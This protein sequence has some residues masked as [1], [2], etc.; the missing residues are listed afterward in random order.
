MNKIKVAAFNELKTFGSTKKYLKYNQMNAS[1]NEVHVMFNNAFTHPNALIRYA[2]LDCV[3]YAYLIEGN[4]FGATTVSKSISNMPL[5]SIAD[6]GLGIGDFINNEI[7][8]IKFN[9]ES[10]IN[11]VRTNPSVFDIPK[12]SKKR[13]KSS[14]VKYFYNHT[15]KSYTIH[16]SAQISIGNHPHFMIID[17]NLYCAVKFNRIPDDDKS[18]ELQYVP[19]NSLEEFEVTSG[20]D[21]SI[22]SSNNKFPTLR[23]YLW[24][25]RRNNYINSMSLA[26]VS[27]NIRAAFAKQHMGMNNIK[28]K[29]I[30][31]ATQ[32]RINLK[33]YPVNGLIN[34]DIENNTIYHYNDT[35]SSGNI[36]KKRFY[37]GITGQKAINL[38]A[39]NQTMKK[40]YPS[41]DV[42]KF[43][44][45]IQVE[46]DD[47]IKVIEDSSILEQEDGQYRF[48]AIP[49]DTPLGNA[50][51]EE[52]MYI[53]SD[54][55]HDNISAR[56]II[57]KLDTIGIDKYNINQLESNS[58]L[59]INIIFDYVREEGD[60]LEN[61]IN[62]FPCDDGVTR[63][64]DDDEV[65]KDIFNN[66][67]L[68]KEFL[69]TILAA[70]NFR[71]KHR[72]FNNIDLTNVDEGTAKII[73]LINELNHKIDTNNA[74][75]SASK[76]WLM[77]IVRRNTSNPKLIEDLTK[78]FTGYGDTGWADK[79]IQDIHANKDPMVQNIIKEF[80]TR[81]ETARREGLRQAKNYKNF[82]RSIENDARAAGMNATLNSVIDDEGRLIRPFTK[83]WENKQ[84]ELSDAVKIAKAKFGDNSIQHLNAKHQYEKFLFTTSVSKFKNAVIPNVNPEIEGDTITVN[85]EKARLRLQYNALTNAPE[86]FSEYKKLISR[87]NEIYNTAVGG[88]LSKEQEDEIG[89]IVTKIDTLTNLYNDDGT[90]KIGQDYKKAAALNAY[91]KGMKELKDIF[92]TKVVAPNFYEKL[93]DNLKI[94]RR[95][96]TERD[97]EGRLLVNRDEL[98]KIPEYVNAKQ[99]LRNNAKAVITDYSL[100]MKVDELYEILGEQYKAKSKASAAIKE[101]HAKDEWGI[102]D[103]RKIP[104]YGHLRS[105]EAIKAQTVNDFRNHQ[106]NGLPYGGIIR[107]TPADDYIYTTEFWK[108]LNSGNKL[109]DAEIGVGE[110]IN[111]ILVKHWNNRSRVLK[112]WELSIEELLGVPPVG[113]AASKTK[114]GLI[115]L[116][117]QLNIVKNARTDTTGGG[118]A[119]AA[120]IEAECDVTYN[121]KA[122]NE[123]WSEVKRTNNR[124]LIS[125]WES[126]FIDG[127]R[128]D[129]TPIPNSVIYSIIRPKNVL[130]EDVNNKY[131][132]EE[133][134]MAKR[135]ER[136]NFRDVETPY[137][138]M[139]RQEVL[140][141][142]GIG[143]EEYRKWFFNNHYWNP[144]ER[145]YVPIRIWTMKEEA[146]SIFNSDKVEWQPKSNNLI[147]TEKEEL[148]NPERNK[149]NVPKYLV[150][151][152]YD[153]PAYTSLN[154]YQHKIIEET[155]KII[156][157]QVITNSN[158]SY[159][160]KGYLPAVVK[161]KPF[162]ATDIPKEILKFGGFW[163]KKADNIS[164]KE[165]NEVTFTR[166]YDIPNQ[167][168]KQLTSSKSKDLVPVPK[169]K[170]EGETDE[171]FTQRVEEALANNREAREENA[172]IHASLLNKDWESVMDAF[173]KQS[174]RE[175]AINVNKN[176]LYMLD[177]MLLN[178]EAYI[179]NSGRLR[180]DRNRSGETQTEYVKT[181]RT[182]TSDQVREY[183][184]RVVFQQFKNPNSG[185]L[186]VLGSLAQ[187]ITGSKYMMMNISGGIANVLTGSANIFME[188]MAG[189]YVNHKYWELAKLKWIKNS[190]NFVSNMY[191]DAATSLEDA[192][193]KYTKIIDFDKL[194]EVEQQGASKYVN[195]ARSLMFSPQTI[196]E[197]FMQSTMLLAM[198]ES[199]RV[200]E[201]ANGVKIM[202][203]ELYRRNQEEKAL[204]IILANNNELK[205]EWEAFK[206]L[207]ASDKS[208]QAKYDTFTRNEVRD[209][210]HKHF[211]RELQK[212]YVK[213]RK[214][215][216]EN[217]ERDFE[218]N[219]STVYSQ[220]ELVD[221]YAELKSDSIITEEAFSKF[222][223]KVK[224]VNKKVHG[225]YDKVG[226]ARIEHFWW[227]GI[228]MQYHKHL[229]PGF[230]KRY[231]VNSYYNETLETIE[232]GSYASL[233]QFLSIPF[234]ELDKPND[235]KEACKAIQNIAKE[236]I[237]FT[238]N[239]N[240]EWGILP[241]HEKANIR[242]NVAEILYLV[243]GVAGAI[244]LCGI[245]DDDEDDVLYNLAMYQVDRLVTEVA[246]FSPI[247]AYAEFDKLWS[248]PVAVQQTL[249][250]GLS[251]ISLGASMLMDD[252]ITAEYTT[253]R[254]KG[255]NKFEV[256]FIRNV[257]VVRNINRIMEMPKHNKF[258]KLQENALGIIN[259]KAIAKSI[260]E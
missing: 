67:T 169:I 222:V 230:K 174:A 109:S 16:N 17:H 15:D 29:E 216:L 76:K 93:E 247:G 27:S 43:A 211:S 232:K 132:H 112:T 118:A 71:D 201:T 229:Y 167:S 140:D 226:A 54:M 180:K 149:S 82:L 104:Q 248:S 191:N 127:Y 193:I 88:I 166:D 48:S 192:L 227:G 78:I 176:L 188:R 162:E 81:L 87:I 3:K 129:G 233:A 110:A 158:Q 28:S 68:E 64:I 124:E 138:Y 231:R 94:I 172:K 47:I 20:M 145:R 206:K 10:E 90:M 151:S 113:G 22:I 40:K 170:L 224:E 243:A 83:E 9:S 244:I 120:F 75:V 143:S 72:L 80:E 46:Y 89:H 209:F 223:N 49:S 18:A 70:I 242:R 148:L 142:Y 44:T 121:D 215:F 199:H 153:N 252:S 55:K 165:D 130:E 159:V 58:E 175:Y 246:S 38:S 61:S 4:K 12:Y 37:I 99:W 98:M 114:L 251:V 221:G 24:V 161:S 220:F 92:Y 19:V 97:S 219:Y 31:K 177:N 128:E 257:P 198:M 196:G 152:G 57:N 173:I 147:Y 228:V 39:E 150:G 202:N 213:I 141:E 136:D 260:F 65:I 35:D 189:E 139:A 6:N 8:G 62:H 131:V 250:D 84:H 207:I 239:I 204:E 160:D 181:A 13:L 241:E 42:N 69:N 190:V 125:A 23:N 36:I 66:K 197:H 30:S 21:D 258:Y 115:D 171:E 240:L 218:T 45:L 126:V 203:L 156:N 134:T 74:I 102:V 217:A 77:E 183:T 234:D 255:L 178:H 103:G 91:D 105:A 2:A 7:K 85:Y 253:G 237:N 182:N 95:Y 59:A 106:S 256:M 111:N 53:V 73:R 25:L 32:K 179:T 205:T 79:W 157:G 245:G 137:Y 52:V 101:F 5:Y 123:D 11:Y 63:R 168:L 186:N 135:L 225:V 117:D 214:E 200:V 26:L 163:G 33:D 119:V 194:V 96:E 235:Y 259:Y 236:L 34:S 249:K 238:A 208:L 254:Y 1:E 154:E 133:R 144:Y 122:F 185:M 184:R 146:L 108:K 212:E 195:R 210:I 187:N 41:M 164:W 50:L 86:E 116:F 56:K 60:L 100:G 107:A 155:S 14:G 51:R